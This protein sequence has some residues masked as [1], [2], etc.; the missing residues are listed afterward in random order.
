MKSIVTANPLLYCILLSIAVISGGCAG[1]AGGY[2]VIQP[3]K[4]GVVLK[5]YT[6][7]ELVAVS[8]HNVPLTSADMKRITDLVIK[9]VKQEE[10]TRFQE[11]NPATPE[12]ST[13]R[14]KLLFTKYDKGNA[15]A[16]AMLAGLGQMHIDAD[17]LVED[18]TTNELLAKYK[19]TKTFAWGGIYG[20]SATIESI[21]PAFAKSVAT[22]ILKP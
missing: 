13:I 14:Y 21:E 8:D 16:R 3:L 7:L 12:P 20:G 22:V 11:I 18:P 2:Q 1:N 5:N 9:E 17:I 19:V 4:K 15:F 10:S 6:N